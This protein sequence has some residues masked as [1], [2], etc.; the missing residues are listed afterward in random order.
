MTT[1]ELLHNKMRESGMK[2]NTLIDRSGC[3]EKAMRKYLN[4]STTSGPYLTKILEE[5]KITV[6]E[7]NAC[8]NV[9]S[10]G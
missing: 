9:K 3:S 1:R 5:L 8:S 4:G 10:E 7:W 6:E 2:K